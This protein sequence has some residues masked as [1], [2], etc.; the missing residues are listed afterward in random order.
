VLRFTRCAA[1]RCQ[2]D[3]EQSAVTPSCACSALRS[4]EIEIAIAE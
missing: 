4:I 1:L 3:A 2:V